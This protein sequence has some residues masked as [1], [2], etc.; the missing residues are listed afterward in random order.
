MKRCCFISFGVIF[1]ATLVF[2]SFTAACPAGATARSRAESAYLNGTGGNPDILWTN[3]ING[4]A[5][6]CHLNCPLHAKRALIPNIPAVWNIL[7]ANDCDCDRSPDVVWI[8]PATGKVVSLRRSGLV[9]GEL[10]I[11]GAR[12]P[13]SMVVQRCHPRSGVF[14]Y[15]KWDHIAI[16]PPACPLSPGDAPDGVLLHGLCIFAPPMIPLTFPL[17]PW[18]FYRSCRQEPAISAGNACGAP[19]FACSL[20]AA[21][22]SLNQER[23]VVCPIQKICLIWERR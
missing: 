6:V 1:T 13:P 11:L 8:Y 21:V 7:D 3:S 20:M 12:A 19:L 15:R 9:P 10:E 14:P 23:R 2:A 18:M 17:K 16:V 22:Q 5:I 4:R